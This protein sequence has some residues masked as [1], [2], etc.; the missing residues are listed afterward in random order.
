MPKSSPIHPK[1]H[2]SRKTTAGD[3]TWNAQWRDPRPNAVIK[4]PTRSL[5]TT[6]ALKAQTYAREL[7]QIIAQ[8]EHWEQPSEKLFC[9]FV[10][11]SLW[12][13]VPLHKHI[14]KT[15]TEFV[16]TYAQIATAAPDDEKNREQNLQIQEL[17]ERHDHFKV[18]AV[19]AKGLLAKMGQKIHRDD[20]S[21]VSIGYAL[22]KWVKSYQGRDGDHT[23][24][25]RNDLRRFVTVFGNAHKVSA[26]LAKPE[27]A[28]DSKKFDTW[29]EAV[30]KADTTLLGSLEGRERDIEAWLRGLIAAH[31][32]RKGQPISAGRRGAMRKHI[33]RFMTDSGVTVDRKEI[34]NPKK[35][36]ITI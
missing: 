24:I 21:S 3:A 30:K 20:A 16:K 32:K 19:K 23:T 31:G 18:E 6:D 35:R 13:S 5:E 9:E 26:E 11:E 22:E 27:Y 4:K 10:R 14:K 28:T 8:P 12:G 34:S 25:V 7:S 29:L 36:S 17:Q 2:L 1:V 33:I 15:D